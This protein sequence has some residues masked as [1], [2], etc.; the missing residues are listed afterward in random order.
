MVQDSREVRRIRSKV[1]RAIGLRFAV[2]VLTG[3]LLVWGLLVI[4]LRTT[5]TISSQSLLWGLLGIPVAIVAGIVIARRRTPSEKSIRALLDHYGGYGGLLMSAEEAELGG[6]TLPKSRGDLL[7]V[8]WDGR[9]QFGVLLCSAAFVL[10]GFLLPSRML[11]TASANRLEVSAEVEKLA[12][13]LE[14]LKEELVLPPD[15][16]KSLED[17]LSKL[18][19]T[20]QGNDPGKTWEAMD[21]LEQALTQAAMEAAD[22][23]SKDA[24]SSA[25]AEEIANALRTAHDQ[26]G[27]EELTEAMKLLAKAV[28]ELRDESDLI[29]QELSE[30]LSEALKEKLEKGELT[31]EDLEELAKA[32]GECKGG[33]LSKLRQLANAKLIDPSA[34]KA[35]EGECQINPDALA[36][37]LAKCEGEKSVGICLASG[38]RPSRGGISRGRGDAAMTWSNGTDREGLEFKEQALPPGA[39][40]SLKEAQLQAI[41]VGNPESDQPRGDSTGGGLDISTAGSGSARTQIILPEHRKAVQR[42]FSRPGRDKPSLPY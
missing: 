10:T 32:L 14:V 21:H 18:H 38:P 40:A 13:Q 17:A 37:I 20:A 4:I 23:A 30:A 31:P 22:Q 2:L 27:A 34:L 5:L 7:S 41:S 26:M 28:N 19:E 15:R 24:R 1:A 29:D 11:N 42:Y 33:K 8:R 3:W 35:C 39:V 16:A 9:R 12:Q 6:W 25:S 36:E